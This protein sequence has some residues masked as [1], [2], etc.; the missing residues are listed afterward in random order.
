MQLTK[1]L[2]N[3]LRLR[4]SNVRKLRTYSAAVQYTPLCERTATK[5]TNVGNLLK[6]RDAKLTELRTLEDHNP[7]ELETEL[8]WLMEDVLCSGRSPSSTNWTPIEFQ[9][10]LLEAENDFE[11]LLRLDLEELSSLWRR[12][13]QDRV[14]IQYLTETVHWR[15]LI[16]AVGPG[17]LIPR[18]E[19][20]QLIEFANHAIQSN[21]ALLDLPWVDL[22]CGSGAIGLSLAKSYPQMKVLAV[23]RSSICIQCTQ[24]NIERLD[25]SDRVFTFEG[26]WYE[27]LNPWKGRIGGILSNPPYIP[28]HEI[29]HLQIEV[30]KHEPHEALDGGRLEGVQS[31][32]TILTQAGVY[33]APGGFLAVETQGLNQTKQ[34]KS[35]F[36]ATGFDQ[37]EIQCDYY[38]IKRF[39]TAFKTTKQVSVRCHNN[40]YKT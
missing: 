27:P 8:R 17:V 25:L 38:R 32:R 39:L 3:S 20:E 37:M 30:S 15:D 19:T 21:P 9:S 11:C 10:L 6:W 5:S 4:V 26:D 33:L 35:E 29:P 23:D 31:L 14:P 7:S 13:I 22:G 1:L 28:A 36:Q 12:R 34:L 16:L 40:T 24:R 18:P 2:H